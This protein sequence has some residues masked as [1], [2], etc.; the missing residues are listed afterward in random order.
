MTWGAFLEFRFYSRS[1][2]IRENSLG[3]EEGEMI[4]VVSG[5]PELGVRLS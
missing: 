2:V 4:Q 3:V 5:I 1:I